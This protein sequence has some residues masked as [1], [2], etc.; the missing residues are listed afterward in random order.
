MTTSYIL[1]VK[2]TISRTD[3]AKM[4]RDL[5]Q[6]FQRVAS[7]FTTGLKTGLTKAAKGFGGAL[8][9]ILSSK[10]FWGV[11]AGLVGTLAGVAF[12]NPFEKL[13]QSINE[14]LSKMRTTAERAAQLGTT[15]GRYAEIEQIAK[16]AGVK[17]FDAIV[18]SFQEQLELSRQGQQ[19]LLQEFTQN[20][21]TLT[22]FVQAIQS[23]KDLPEDERASFV[24][25]IFGRGANIQLAGLLNT[26]LVERRQQIFGNIS[27]ETFGAA[28]DKLAKNSELQ[29]ILIRQT[30]VRD[31]LA[32]SKLINEGVIRSQEQ[33]YRARGAVENIQLGNYGEFAKWEIQSAKWQQ[34]TASFQTT[35]LEYVGGLR[36]MVGEFIDFIHEV[37]TKGWRAIF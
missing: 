21:D 2:P 25:Q 10:S 18:S 19:P 6:R 3:G 24:K 32:K 11:V 12:N 15:T 34:E 17:N 16:S 9:S 4:E 28:V 33:V 7:K 22:A 26:N 20:K 5:N 29:E 31:I 13:T 1:N 14:L 8:T 30:E 35:L 36:D 37:R 27:N 23:L